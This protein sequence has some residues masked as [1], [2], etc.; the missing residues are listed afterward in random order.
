MLIALPNPEGDFTATL[1]AP[2][3]GDG[4]F[5]SPADPEAVSESFKR[6]FPIV[7]G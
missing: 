7:W 1:F 3:T 5:A 2:N 6:E 4:G